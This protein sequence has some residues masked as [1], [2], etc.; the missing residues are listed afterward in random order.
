M[1]D[2][3]DCKPA[4]EMVE[5]PG[6]K[7]KG[8]DKR[9]KAGAVETVAT[10]CMSGFVCIQVGLMEYQCMAENSAC[11]SNFSSLDLHMTVCI[12]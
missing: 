11:E 6:P 9:K 12:I 1:V 2:A 4:V 3:S 7:P 10:P 8:A 5:R